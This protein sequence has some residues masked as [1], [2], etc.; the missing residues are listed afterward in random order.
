[1]IEAIARWWCKRY[2]HGVINV[3][4]LTYEC[5]QCFRLTYHGLNRDFK[6]YPKAQPENVSIKTRKQKQKVRS[7]A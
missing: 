5:S 3:N 4:S 2:H 7:I 1:M 6:K